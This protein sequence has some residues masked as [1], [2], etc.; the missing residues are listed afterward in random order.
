MTE[1]AKAGPANSEFARALQDSGKVQEILAFTLAD[2]A[3]GVELKMIREIVVPPPITV[4]P[5]AEGAVMGICSVRGVLITVIDLKLRL[6]LA[7]RPRSRRSRILLTTTEAGEQLGLFVDE[8]RQVVRLAEHDVEFTASLL[9]AE[10][11]DYVWGIG[12]PSSGLIVLLD[13]KLVLPK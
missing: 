11:A 5:R 1:L 2:E 13:L 6:R 7:A 4:V 10:S 12:R 3:Y 8:V 9:G